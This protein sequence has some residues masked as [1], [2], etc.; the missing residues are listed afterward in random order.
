MKILLLL[1]SF[2][3]L[4]FPI[5]A[6]LEG[7]EPDPE[8]MVEQDP[9]YANLPLPSEILVVF[10]DSSA[11]GDTLSRYIANYYASKRNIPSV[12]V[13]GISSLPAPKIY[14]SDTAYVLWTSL[15]LPRKTK[16]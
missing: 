7:E 8:S 14:D 16:Q 4:C 5:L 10:A 9:T 13:F 2:S 3:L 11:R 6:Q 15:I 1:L 12:N